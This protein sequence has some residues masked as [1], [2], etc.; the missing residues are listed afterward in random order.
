MAYKKSHDF[1][2]RLFSSFI[3]TFYKRFSFFFFCLFDFPQCFERSDIENT[4]RRRSVA[5]NWLDGISKKAES[6]SVVKHPPGICPKLCVGDSGHAVRQL[7]HFVLTDWRETVE[8]GKG[9]WWKTFSNSLSA[10]PESGH[11]ITPVRIFFLIPTIFISY[12]PIFI[13]LITIRCNSYYRKVDV[14]RINDS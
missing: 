6:E 4:P 8:E 9:T 12:D 3:F 10:R 7:L 5:N 2:S 14:E 11:P 13:P 1:Y